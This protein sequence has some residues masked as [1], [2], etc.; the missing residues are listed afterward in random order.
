MVCEAHGG[1]TWHFRV[2]KTL[3]M[4]HEIFNDLE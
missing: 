4:L 2:R 1:L 3:E